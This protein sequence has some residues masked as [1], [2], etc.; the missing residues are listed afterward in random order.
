[1]KQPT[2]EEMLDQI[3]TLIPPVINAG[4]VRKQDTGDLKIYELHIPKVFDEDK[5]PILKADKQIK[6]V[7]DCSS[8][9]E[10]MRCTKSPILEAPYDL[11]KPSLTWED[12]YKDSEFHKGANWMLE[13]IVGSLR[14]YPDLGGDIRVMEEVDRI[15]REA[16]GK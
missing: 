7:C 14:G 10:A 12:V 11:S 3:V 13:A 16:L 5:E 15:V 9:L 2:I 4:W 1:M 8:P 6:D